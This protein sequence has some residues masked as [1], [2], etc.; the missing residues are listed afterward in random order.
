MQL[1]EGGEAVAGLSSRLVLEVRDSVDSPSL[2]KRL[3]TEQEV[4][5]LRKHAND[6][7]S[8]LARADRFVA[9]PG[10]YSHHKQGPPLVEKQQE[11]Y[12]PD[13]M[14]REESRGMGNDGG[15]D[16]KKRRVVSL[17]C[18]LT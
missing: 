18:T 7:Q 2:P 9:N 13:E 3:P 14:N 11:E 16:P 6:I 10:P 12:Q 4:A 15:P 8:L 5:A 1:K 17:E